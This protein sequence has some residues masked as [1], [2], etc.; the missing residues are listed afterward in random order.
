[1]HTD[2][3]PLEEDGRDERSLHLQS[4][5]KGVC[6]FHFQS[7]GTFPLARTTTST[8]ESGCY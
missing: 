4:L 5:Y 3:H 2:N 1:M 6:V 7:L 8:S